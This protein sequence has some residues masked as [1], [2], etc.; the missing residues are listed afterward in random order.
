[1]EDI[2][3]FIE[4]RLVEKKSPPLTYIQRLLLRE[5]LSESKKSY[6]EIAN[7]NN[8]SESY[9]KQFVAPKLW[10]ILSEVLEEKVNKNNCCLV[11]EQHWKQDLAEKRKPTKRQLRKFDL[12]TMQLP[13]NSAFYIERHPIEKNCYQQILQPRALIRIKAPRQMG[14]SSLVARVMDY[15]HQQNCATVSLSLNQAETELFLNQRRFLRW[16][17]ANAAHQLGLPPKLD[18]YWSD[19]L[20]DLVCCTFYFAEY[21]L[22]EIDRPVV[23]ALD[24][25]NQ[26]F[27]YPNLARDFFAMLRSWYEE[28]RDI[29]SWQKLRFILS[30]ST[31]I[32]IPF[33]TN[34]SPFNV[35]MVINLPC[36]DQSQIHQ[37]AKYYELIVSDMEVCKLLEMTGGFPFLVQQALYYSHANAMPLRE[38]L[39]NTVEVNKI[40][41]N[42]LA[43][44]LNDLEQDANLI[45][46][47]Q[48]V[49]TSGSSELDMEVAFK[50]KSLGLIYLEGTKAK[51]SCEL[52]RRFF[53]HYWS[54]TNSKDP[55]FVSKRF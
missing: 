16:L 37:L 43:Q 34:K 6:E 42:H 4:N 45:Q 11:L 9:I 41:N 26:L 32:Y 36:F 12:P 46:G 27:A 51:I 15:A 47:L 10:L 52:Y 33:K 21:L 7:E 55:G 23:L 13:L 31:E 28:T 24:E 50:L 1:M 48:E 2:I 20:G 38:L 39:Q 25:I 49:L 22:E 44:K 29:S 5:I 19:D 14:K 53:V 35:G 18:E 30:H 17:C 54:L 40:Y 3:K 8:Y